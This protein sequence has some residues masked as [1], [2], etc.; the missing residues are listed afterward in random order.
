M[1]SH[2]PQAGNEQL[3]EEVA[4]Q[5][6][7]LQRYETLRGR[8]RRQMGYREGYPVT[9][10]PGWI[11]SSVMALPLRPPEKPFVTAGGPPIT[12]PEYYDTGATTA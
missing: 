1:Q 3:E 8:R 6:R 2:N 7:V 4:R 12:V 10:F 9:L 11:R 5:Q